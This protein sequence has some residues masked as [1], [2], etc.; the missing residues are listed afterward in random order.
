MYK[1]KQKLRPKT[2]ASWKNYKSKKA[3]TKIQPT[4]KNSPDSGFEPTTLVL[5]DLHCNCWPIC[6]TQPFRG[7]IRLPRISFYLSLSQ[8]EHDIMQL[9]KF[10]SSQSATCYLL[11]NDS[12]FIIP[13]DI[14]I[15]NCQRPVE[16]AIR[17]H[18]LP[19]LC[20]HP[21]NDSE[22]ALLALPIRLGGLG[23][24]DPQRKVIKFQSLP[25]WLP[26]S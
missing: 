19:K 9:S 23:I 22:R 24:F 18:L 6:P 1:A 11:C 20:I 16:K 26:P 4:K 21:P 14:F 15:E 25:L 7:S 17:L 3:V 5:R 12:W 13:L 2:L 8:W 10:A